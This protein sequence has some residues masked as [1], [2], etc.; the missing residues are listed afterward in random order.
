MKKFLSVFFVAIASFSLM[1]AQSVNVEKS[2]QFETPE[3]GWIKVLQLRNGNT[4]FFCAVD[5][6][7]IK[8]EIYNHARKLVTTKMLTGKLWDVEKLGA[9]E[10][11]ICALF[12]ANGEVALFFYQH[13]KEP[14]LIR[15]RIS[16]DNGAIIKEDAFPTQRVPL[17]PTG[18]IGITVDKDANSACYAVTARVFTTKGTDTRVM[19]FDSNHNKINEA[20]FKPSGYRSTGYNSVL[21]DGNKAVYL[22]TTA[23]KGIGMASYYCL[24]KLEVGQ[25]T[26][27]F[28]T[29]FPDKNF[30]MASSVMS[31]DHDLNKILIM[32]I[33]PSEEKTKDIDVVY[34]DAFLWFLDPASLSI[35]NTRDLGGNKVVALAKERFGESWNYSNMPRNFI[36]NRDKTITVTG[37]SVLAI[38]VFSLLGGVGISEFSADG[39]EVAGNYIYKKQES[40][41]GFG[42]LYL[43]NKSRNIFNESSVGTMSYDYL[44]TSVGRYVIFN[45]LP[46]YHGA[47]NERERKKP[48]KEGDYSGAALCFKLG[49][50]TDDMSFLLDK[51]GS[52]PYSHCDIG[53][54]HFDPDTDTYACLITTK[55]TKGTKSSIAWISFK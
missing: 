55:S 23:S 29:L 13:T 6:E 28:N 14:D 36:V 49:E 53:S 30:N 50:G 43:Y 10:F 40:R 47:E 38:S 7:G 24:G 16:T 52:D 9:P 33:V 11:K 1:H 35:I 25:S 51:K 45:D 27:K 17:H 5:G 19:H 3:K 21:V 32:G 2:E 37:E 15:L 18:L 41:R 39:T 26:F 46:E 44:R 34:Y 48:F 4:M 54:S 42:Y 8:L 22:L 31:Y 12:E 20:I